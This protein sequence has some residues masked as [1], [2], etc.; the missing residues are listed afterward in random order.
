MKEP[1]RQRKKA[2]TAQAIEQ[3]AVELF[4]RQG[5]DGTTLEQIAEAADV[6]KQ[7]VLRYFKSKEDIAFAHRNRIFDDFARSLEVRSGTVLDHWRQYIADTST[8][9]PAIMTL[10]NWFDFL[11]TDDRLYA[12]QLRLNQRYQDT[13]AIAFA[14]EAG[15]DPNQ[16]IFAHALAALLVSGNS[17]VA[18]MTV[19]HG[20][21]KD[22]PGNVS[23]VIDLAATLRR[24]TIPPA[25]PR[26][27]KRR[28]RSP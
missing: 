21:P 7:T 8:R 14:D 10:R 27:A 6:H 16:D 2:R 25:K 9:P 11:A 17:E 26:R 13:L 5:F 23:Q 19:R 28:P 22:V 1:L 4:A 20:R 24:E 3:A 15:T 12:Y 18:R